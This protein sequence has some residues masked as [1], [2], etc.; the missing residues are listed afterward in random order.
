MWTPPCT[1]RLALPARQ[2]VPQHQRAIGGQAKAIGQERQV[3]H[4]GERAIEFGRLDGL[5]VN[6]EKPQL[7]IV[8]ARALGKF[9]PFVVADQ[10]FW[11]C[12]HAYIS[13]HE[14]SVMCWREKARTGTAAVASVT[15]S[16]RGA[17][18]LN[19]KSRVIGIPKNSNE[20]ELRYGVLDVRRRVL[21]GSSS[22]QSL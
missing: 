12:S 20:D 4:G 21:E 15:G 14:D 2:R 17:V 22:K 11:Y 3:E 9:E 19:S 5:A 6:I 18:S 7:A 8:P 16:I 10:Y 13:S 1:V